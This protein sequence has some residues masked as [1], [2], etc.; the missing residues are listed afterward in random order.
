MVDDTDGR[1]ALGLRSAHH[2]YPEQRLGAI[3]LSA[4]LM[5][6]RFRARPILKRLEFCWSRLSE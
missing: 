1:R 6:H 3:S 2:F 4:V 5:E